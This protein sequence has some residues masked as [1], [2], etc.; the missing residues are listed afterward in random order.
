MFDDETSPGS[1]MTVAEMV[2]VAAMAAV[3]SKEAEE[4]DIRDA[5]RLI[6]PCWK[7]GMM[8]F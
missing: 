6:V 2:V 1:V 8:A 3:C 7:T 5:E 4:S